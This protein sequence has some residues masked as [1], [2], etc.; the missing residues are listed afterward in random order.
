MILESMQEA[1]LQHEA[2][3]IASIESTFEKLNDGHIYIYIHIYTSSLKKNIL[4]PENR[5]FIKT[6][7]SFWKTASWQV[8]LLVSG[9][10]NWM[11][12]LLISKDQYPR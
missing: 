5:W 2:C 4:A 3:K 11:H 1:K 12:M 7:A 6:I 9:R 8:D 10:V